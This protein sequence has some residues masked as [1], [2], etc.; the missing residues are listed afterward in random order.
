MLT[1]HSL[2]QKKKKGAVRFKRKS[3]DPEVQRLELGASPATFWVPD[4]GELRS[5]CKIQFSHP[6]D[7]SS[8]SQHPC[9]N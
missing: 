1:A 5:L 3:T 2:D 7:I 9:D 4:V 8:T 6:S